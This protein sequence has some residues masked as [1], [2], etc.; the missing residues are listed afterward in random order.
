MILQLASPPCVRLQGMSF[1][2]LVGLVF[3]VAFAED[4]GPVHSFPSNFEPKPN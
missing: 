1:G 4:E 3:L 2:W